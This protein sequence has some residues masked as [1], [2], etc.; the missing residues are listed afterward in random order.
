MIKMS[1]AIKCRCGN[2]K[3]LVSKLK[4]FS[5]GNEVKVGECVLECASCGKQI[6]YGDEDE[7]DSE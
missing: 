5:L 7:T 6:L 1:V 4:H 2:N 3:F